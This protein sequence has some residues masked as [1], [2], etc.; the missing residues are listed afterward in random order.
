MGTLTPTQK[1]EYIYP[2]KETT[3]SNTCDFFMVFEAFL[4]LGRLPLFSFIH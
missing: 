2:K 4:I 1:A 3:S